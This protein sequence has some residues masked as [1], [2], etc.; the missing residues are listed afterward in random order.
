MTR[1]TKRPDE[2]LDAMI[3]AERRVTPSAERRAANWARVEAGLA[4]PGGAG[5]GAGAGTG[6]L[7]KLAGLVL[8]VGAAAALVGSLPSRGGDSEPAK[9]TSAQAEVATASSTKGALRAGDDASGSE[10]DTLESPAAPRRSPGSASTSF[11]APPRVADGDERRAAGAEDHV[12][13][14]GGWEA[15]LRLLQRAEAALRE[16]RPLDALALTKEYRRRWPDGEFVEAVAAT[17]TLARCALGDRDAHAGFERAWPRS[18]YGERI[19][20]GCSNDGA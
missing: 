13:G 18:L 14:D 12:D 3:E 6:A 17:Q 9:A 20:K 2:L 1:A 19:R 11:A 15:E 8:V 4:G 16:G 5:A 7:G 10:E